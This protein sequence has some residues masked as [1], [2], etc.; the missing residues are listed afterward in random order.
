MV[1]VGDLVVGFF[2]VYML[3]RVAVTYCPCLSLRVVAIRPEYKKKIEIQEGAQ[4]G[5]GCRLPS[6]N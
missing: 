1:D 3:P 2:L 5:A 4:M 6:P